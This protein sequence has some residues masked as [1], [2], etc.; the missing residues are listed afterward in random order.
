MYNVSKFVR[1][2]PDDEIVEFAGKDF[3]AEFK[4]SEDDLEDYLIG[5]LIEG[6]HENENEHEN[7]DPHS[8]SLVGKWL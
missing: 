5:N 8:H 2:H 3:T 1:K 6:R 4:G 7:V